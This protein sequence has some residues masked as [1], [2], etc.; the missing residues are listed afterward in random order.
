MTQA[1]KKAVW[2]QINWDEV[3]KEA[4]E[5][6]KALIRFETVNPP[7]NEKPAAEYIPD[8]L[9]DEGLAPELFESAEKRSNV[10]CRIPGSGQ[11]P[12]LL[13]NGH[14]D[15]VPA[16]SDQ[17]RFPPFEAREKDGWLYGRGAVDMK[18]MDENPEVVKQPGIVAEQGSV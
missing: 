9:R 8:I 1:F 18:N 3:H 15:V 14:L 7:G 11:A 13:L 12:P 4:I 10:V 2:E 6:L 17:W 5:H 16:E